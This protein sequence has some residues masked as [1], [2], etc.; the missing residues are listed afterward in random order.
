MMF[1]HRKDLLNLMH[2]ISGGFDICHSCM[3][4]VQ[5]QKVLRAYLKLKTAS[6][7]LAEGKAGSAYT[8]MAKQATKD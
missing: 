4:N 7:Q 1:P 5:L 6:L 8:P 2:K 3:H